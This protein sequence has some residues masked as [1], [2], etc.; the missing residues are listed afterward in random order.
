[1][2]RLIRLAARL[3]PAAWRTRYGAEFAALLDATQPG[4]L[5]VWDVF[6]GALTMRMTAWN[7]GKITAGCALAGVVVAGS[8]T[9]SMPAEYVS[10]AV[11]GTAPGDAGNSLPEH[12]QLLQQQI[13]SRSSLAEIIQRPA[14]DL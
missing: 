1:M 10:T 14:F 8:L 12:L 3:Y 5:D 11:L 13:L 6:R 7:F 4:G 2:R 9:Y